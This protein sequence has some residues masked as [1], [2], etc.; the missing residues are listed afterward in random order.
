M[1]EVYIPGI[2]VV[3]QETLVSYLYL[4]LIMAGAAATGVLLGMFLDLV[5]PQRRTS[6]AVNRGVNQPSHET[7]IQAQRSQPREAESRAQIPGLDV[8]VARHIGME[9]L[10][11]LRSGEVKVKLVSEKCKG[12]EVVLDLNTMELR[13][14]EEDGVLR[15]LDEPKSKDEVVL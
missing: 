13:C 11:K 1:A 9:V 6:Q 5:R 12:G 3:P 2:G 8:A 15:G 4:V 14:L 10:E 7:Q